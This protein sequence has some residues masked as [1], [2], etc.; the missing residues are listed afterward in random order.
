NG[1][2]QSGTLLTPRKCRYVKTIAIEFPSQ[3][4]MQF[5]DIGNPPAPKAN[6]ILIETEFSGITNGTERH[7]L[8]GEH[9]WKGVY[10]SKHGY[11]Q[12]GRIAAVGDDVKQFTAGDR[13]FFG[14]YV[15]HRAWNIV[16][17]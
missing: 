17:V 8:M 1:K 15:G 7:A 6:E 10:P 3:G 16:N 12:V 11:Q 4:A 5:A 14:Q 13:V 9:G 2:I